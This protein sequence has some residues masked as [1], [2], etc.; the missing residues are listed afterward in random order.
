MCTDCRLVPGAGHSRV[1]TGWDSV[2]IPNISYQCSWEVPGWARR[3]I[4]T[5]G[6]QSSVRGRDQSGRGTSMVRA[7]VS[8]TSPFLT[9][10]DS[11]S[12]R[13]DYILFST[14]SPPSVQ[15]IPWP[16]HDDSDEELTM[17]NKAWS[18]YDSWNVDDQELPW[19]VEADGK[20]I[21][22]TSVYYFLQIR[23]TSDYRQDDT[24]STGH[25]NLGY[26]GWTRILCSVKREHGS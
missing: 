3:R 15:R 26:F 13:R 19:L 9:S 21:S 8:R 5:P 12:P 4:S 16:V 24:L 22:M 10:Y 25:R 2:P 20:H 17:K 23:I 11:A 18:G 14:K 7:A 6:G 1:F